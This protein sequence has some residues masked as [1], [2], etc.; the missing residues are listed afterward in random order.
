VTEAVPVEKCHHLV[1]CEVAAPALTNV[2]SE[3]E[4]CNLQVT[5]QNTA[6]ELPN[7]EPA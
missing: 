2:A 6:T 3:L 7:V 5:P 1:T 4:Q